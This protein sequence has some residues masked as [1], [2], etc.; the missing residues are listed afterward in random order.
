MF[1]LVSDFINLAVVGNVTTLYAIEENGDP[2]AGCDPTDSENTE[3]QY[4]IKW[5]GWS[6][7]HN[8]WESEWSLK[9]QKVYGPKLELQN[10][11]ISSQ[12]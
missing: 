6:H 12:N 3:V 11:F 2:N 7:I 9:E 10:H 4:L 8:T 1:W 5:K